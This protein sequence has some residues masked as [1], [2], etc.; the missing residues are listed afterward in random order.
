MFP[1]K[2]PCTADMIIQTRA[3]FPLVLRK[4]PA[5]GTYLI[6][7]AHQFDR[8]L[9]SARTR[10]RPVIFTLVFLHAV[11]KEH[12]RVLFLNRYFYKKDSFYHLSA[13]YCISAGAL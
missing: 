9:Y 11:R 5:A 3:F 12:P 7:L 4:V 2:A 13:S 10:I 1:G 8:I 6:Q